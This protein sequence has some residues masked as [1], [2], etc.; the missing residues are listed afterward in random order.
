MGK[1]LSISLTISEI[2]RDDKLDYCFVRIGENK[3]DTVA[4]TYHL[5]GLV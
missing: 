3:K 5:V 4:M 1:I 2:I